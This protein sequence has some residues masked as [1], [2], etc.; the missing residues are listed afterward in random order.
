MVFVSGCSHGRPKLEDAFGE[1][2]HRPIYIFTFATK[3]SW[4][5]AAHVSSLVYRFLPEVAIHEKGKVKEI[6]DN[7]GRLGFGSLVY[8]RWDEDKECY[9][10]YEGETGP[11]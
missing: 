4:Q 6:I 2:T 7:I 11:A 9:K 3:P 1:I 8:F 5:D 10:H